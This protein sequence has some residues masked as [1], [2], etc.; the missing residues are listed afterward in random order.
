VSQSYLYLPQSF[1]GMVWHQQLVAAEDATVG[2][3]AAG[4]DVGAG[5]DVVKVITINKSVGMV[6]NFL[7]LR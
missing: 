4:A 7:C 3:V 2:V 6:V 1:M 5:T